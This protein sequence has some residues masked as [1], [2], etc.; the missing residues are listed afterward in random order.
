MESTKRSIGITFATQYL[1]LSIQFVAVLI[2]SRLL[3]PADTG[4]FSVAA[5]FMVLLHMFRDFGVVNYVIQERDLTKEKIQSAFGVAILLALA[6]AAVMLVTAPLV[7]RFYARQELIPIL[8]VMALSFAVSPFG[9][10]LFGLYRREMM[11]KSLFF[12]KTASALCHVAVATTLAYRG[13]GAISLAWA[14]FAGILSFGLVANLYRPPG[15]P[16]LPRFTNIGR[17]LS[18]GGM[19]SLGNAAN[20]IGT[21]S[22]DL[23][24]AKMIDMTSVGYFSRGNGLVQLFAKLIATALTTFTL[25]YFSKIKRSG[26]D[27]KQSYLLAINYLTVLSWPFF[28]VMALLAHP[29]V[30]VLYGP[31]WDASV[32]VVELL[33]LAGAIAS[34]SIFATH[35]MIANGQVKQATIEQ[36]LAQP[37]KVIA[38]LLAA[39]EGLRAVAIAMIVAEMAG[40]FITNHYLYHTIGVRITDLA[41]ACRQSALV[42][43]SSMVGPAMVLLFWPVAS[44]ASWQA[45]CVGAV[46]ALAGWLIGVML[47]RHPAWAQLQEALPNTLKNICSNLLDQTGGSDLLQRW[48]NRRARPMQAAS[49][50][51]PP[52]APVMNSGS[53]NTVLRHSSDHAVSV[54]V[55]IPAYNAVDTLARAV[56]SVLV[57]LVESVEIIIIDDGSTD[58]TFSLASE[59]AEANLQ[60]RV[61]R[62]I[63]NGGVSA[64]RNAGIRAARGQFLAFLDADDVWLEG[65]L[66]KQLAEIRRDPAITLVSCN[67]IFVS[68]SGEFL[69]E[70]HVNRPP[71]EGDQSWKTLLIYNFLPTPTVL[72]YR[73]LVLQLGGFDERLPVGEDLDLWIRLA[74]LGKVAVLKEI[75]I[76]YFDSN[77]SLMKRYHAQSPMIVLPMLE[78]HILEQ[79]D[80]LSAAE[81]RKIRGQHSFQS[82]CNL[83]F[84]GDFLACIPVFMHA[85]FKGTRPIKSLTYIPRALM[86]A[87][88]SR[89]TP[90]AH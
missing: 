80:K 20:A 85:V 33:C 42:T 25:P 16:W 87:V 35:V 64:A 17:I 77:G 1:E 88:V 54:S 23:I 52:Q 10:L 57:Q 21:N 51:Q 63:C 29:I 3:T 71:V 18:F 26:G 11:F 59:M 75:L 72:T 60:I 36:M 38:V 48:R 45:L 22:P 83:F 82:G 8:Q 53:S 79:K 9:S 55:I 84:A 32:P 40:I 24:I 70:G 76:K 90:G 30:R 49:P 12:I 46:A 56:D 43:A 44:D 73:H 67:S 61:I 39:A 86:M 81:I 34:M 13:Y 4:I 37:I 31:Q 5:F 50:A 68:E 69:K 65:K 27:L 47:T 78:K 62:L 66:Q 6:V 41:T 14:N 15:L 19:S 89:F 58:T 2:L 7:A 74:M 28:A